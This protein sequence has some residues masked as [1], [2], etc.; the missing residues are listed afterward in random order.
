[1]KYKIMN[2]WD[3]KTYELD[4]TTLEEALKK[5]NLKPENVMVLEGKKTEAKPK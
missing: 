2:R 1:M 5:I 3:K 4:G